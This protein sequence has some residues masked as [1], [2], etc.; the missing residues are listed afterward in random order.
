MHQQ[1][2]ADAAHAGGRILQGEGHRRP[3]GGRRRRR[4]PVPVIPSAARRSSSA[5]DQLEHLGGAARGGAGVHAQR[6]RV[7]VRRPVRVDGVG[8]APL[9][10]D[11]LE[12]P[13]RQ[14][15]HRARGSATASGV[16]VGIVAGRGRRTPTRVR[17]LG[18]RVHDRNG[19]DVGI[20]RHPADRSRATRPTGE[21]RSSPATTSSWS[22]WPAARDHDVA[23]PV[24]VGRRTP[25]C[26]RGHRLDRVLGAEHLAARAGGPGTAPRR[27][28]RARG[29]RARRSCIRISS[30]ITWRSASTSS[31]RNAGAHMTSHSMSR[32]SSSARRRARARRTPCTPWS[33]KAFMSPP[34]A[35][36][37]SAISRAE[38]VGRCP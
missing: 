24:V 12:Q 29:R 9:L 8:E 35:S 31:G 19:S 2:A 37:A 10:A 33:V 27:R 30:R 26:R 5:A 15:R 1:A 25:R 17:L 13:A 11:L 28:S 21:A 7:G 3:S 16:A 20:G 4:A 18:G 34:T 36:T 6:A 38:R 22:R 23:G 14:S 32:P